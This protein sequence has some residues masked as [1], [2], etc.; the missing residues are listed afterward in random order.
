MKKWSGR[1]TKV[2]LSGS[3]MH[4]Y[5]P[6]WCGLRALRS[7]MAIGAAALKVQKGPILSTLGGALSH[8]APSSALQTKDR[9]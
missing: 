3:P 7:D 2:V 8:A 4:A 9:L 1:L 5:V 6:H